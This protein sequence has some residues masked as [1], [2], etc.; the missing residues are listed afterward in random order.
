MAGSSSLAHWYHESA[1]SS[2]SSTTAGLRLRG[3]GFSLS[4]AF[5]YLRALSYC[6]VIVRVHSPESRYFTIA[7]GLEPTLGSLATDTPAVTEAAEH[8]EADRAAGTAMGL[9]SIGQP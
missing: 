3:L 7:A 4:H 5:T 8:E 2:M 6:L 9:R 1:V